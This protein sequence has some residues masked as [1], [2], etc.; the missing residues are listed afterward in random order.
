[1]EMLPML[2]QDF[3]KIE[4]ELFPWWTISYKNKKYFVPYCSGLEQ[5]P[6]IT[7]W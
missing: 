6:V 2:E 4:I 5:L 1:M 7:S 3:L